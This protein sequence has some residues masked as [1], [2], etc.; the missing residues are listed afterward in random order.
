MGKSIK[1]KTSRLEHVPVAMTR[2]IVH[3][4]LD[5]SVH[6][7]VERRT[8]ALHEIL[9]DKLWFIPRS[10]DFHVKRQKP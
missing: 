4:N 6:L 1:S 10:L 8:R 9:F 7:P 3:T 5:Y 2:G